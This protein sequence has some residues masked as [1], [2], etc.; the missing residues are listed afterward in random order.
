M[1]QQITRALKEIGKDD[2]PENYL[3]F[4]CLGKVSI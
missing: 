1:Y 2:H 3:V 4:L